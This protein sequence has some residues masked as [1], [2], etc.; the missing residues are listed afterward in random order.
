[1]KKRL[2]KY[3]LLSTCVIQLT[4]CYAIGYMGGRAMDNMLIVDNQNVSNNPQQLNIKSN[5]NKLVLV[6]QPINLNKVPIL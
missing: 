1:M 6:N 3:I 2:I 4:G 5:S